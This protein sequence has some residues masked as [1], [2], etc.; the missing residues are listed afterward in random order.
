ML[1]PARALLWPGRARHFRC[2]AVPRSGAT[3]HGFV[4]VAKQ[5]ACEAKLI[6][7]PS[8]NAIPRSACARCGQCRG[9]PPARRPTPR[10]RG[11]RHARR[12]RISIR[13]IGSIGPPVIVPT[14]PVRQISL[15]PFRQLIA[16]RA[17]VHRRIVVSSAE[18]G[19]NEHRA[20][21][22][23]V[24]PHKGQQRVNGGTLWQRNVHHE[25]RQHEP[26]AVVVELIMCAGRES[27]PG[28][29]AS[30]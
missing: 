19:A 30:R 22:D 11:W 26:A 2:C 23:R 15:L 20:R 5:S 12:A 17:S 25:A 10:R 16:R 21:Q 3:R 4:I 9:P 28:A 8:D 24:S 1:P 13:P 7:L 18:W 14:D 29:G 27:R 6:L